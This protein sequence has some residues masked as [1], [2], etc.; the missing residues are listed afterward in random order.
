M[1]SALLDTNVLWPS[2]QRDFLLS[3]AAYGQFRPLWSEPILDELHCTQVY[4]KLDQGWV[5]SAADEYAD[6][7]I[8]RM[9][10]HFPDAC[11]AGWE[12]LEG[13]FGLRDP[14]DEHVLAAAVMGHAGVIVTG[15]ADFERALVPADLEVQGPAEFAAYAVDLSPAKAVEAVAAIVDRYRNPATT[16]DLFLD[17]LIA[18]YDMNDAVEGIRSAM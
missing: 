5:S 18:R 7:L 17:Q 3:L 4:K 12:P 13:T 8:Q 9:M 11:V 14:Y 16:M 15:D 1:F 6:H 10:L 2:R